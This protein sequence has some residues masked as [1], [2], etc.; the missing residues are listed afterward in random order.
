MKSS[1]TPARR[2]A[3]RILGDVRKGAFVENALDRRLV[4]ERGLSREDRTFTT[5][6]VYGVLRWRTRLDRIVQRCSA[7]PRKKIH[8]AIADIL[9]LALYQI[10]LLDRVPDHAAVS[11]AVIQARQTSG[12]RRQCLLST[13]VLRKAARDREEVDPSPGDDPGSLA[14][15]FAHPKWLVERWMD[16]LG[17]TSTR[18][19]LEMNNTPARLVIRVNTLKCSRDHLGALLESEEVG[20]EYLEYAPEGIL[21]SHIGRP[22]RALPGYRE[23]FFVVQDPASQM[24]APCCA[25]APEIECWT[26]VPRRA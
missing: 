3:L 16:E 24:I 15:Y 20:T 25:W 17:L 22:V 13:A 14:D 11:Q 21:L 19:I 5:E 10:F 26:R 12:N 23:G 6:L 9:R 8:P 2:L 18:R 1:E 4:S 7:R